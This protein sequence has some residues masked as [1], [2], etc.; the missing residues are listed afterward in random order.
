MPA[1]HAQLIRA[2]DVSTA[3][4]SPT[5]AVCSCSGVLTRTL[6]LIPR[7]QSLSLHFSTNLSQH[8]LQTS[9]LLDGT[10]VILVRSVPLSP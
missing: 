6:A 3:G 10:L 4:Y 9:E 1:D 5:Q 2:L 7:L 8:R